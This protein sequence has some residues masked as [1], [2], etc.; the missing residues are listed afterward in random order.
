MNKPAMKTLAKNMLDPRYRG[1]PQKAC[2]TGAMRQLVMIEGTPFRVYSVLGVMA[3][4]FIRATQKNYPKPWV[5]WIDSEILGRP[6]RLVI[7]DPQYSESMAMESW[8][9]DLPPE[10]LEWYGISREEAAELWTLQSRGFSFE[11]VANGILKEAG[12]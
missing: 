2:S 5:W 8:R 4:I 1:Y 12:K 6:D 3:D 10:I 9:L 11:Q 7:A